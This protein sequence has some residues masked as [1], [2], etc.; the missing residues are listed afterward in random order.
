MYRI[1]NWRVTAMSLLRRGNLNRIYY[2]NMALQYAGNAISIEQDMQRN[3]EKIFQY[4][5]ENNSAYRA[6]LDSKGFDYSDL[7]LINWKDI[8]AITKEDLR[9]FNPV[10]IHQV[11][12]Y[13]KS[14]GSTNSPLRYPASK[15]SA[16][17]IWPNHWTMHAMCGIAPYEKMLMLMGH[18]VTSDSMVKRLYQWLSQFYTV[19]SFD[20]TPENAN[21]MYHLIVNKKIKFLYGYA[22][23][24]YIFLRYLHNNNLHVSLKGIFST[25][26]NVVPVSYDLARK[27][28]DCDLFNQYGAHDGDIFAF[29]CTAHDGLHI[30]HN[31]C[32]LEIIDNEI[33]LTATRNY[34][35]PFIRYRVGDIPFGGALV[36]EKCSCGRTLFRLQGISGRV[37][38]VVVDLDG[39]EVPVIMFTFPLD[40]D[41]SIDKY[42]VVEIDKCIIINII[43][44]KY[45]V[46]FYEQKHMPYIKN[47]LKRSVRFTLNEPLIQ[48]P[49]KK[50]PLYINHNTSV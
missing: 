31:G 23:S 50:V 19:C 27:Y 46:V 25:S 15:D 47:H 22:S 42:Q 12:N 49:N 39:K 14:G 29:E 8:P 21:K 7:L 43:S 35:Y 9:K 10:V 1:M 28:C 6:F 33:Y 45:D 17:S 26:E 34:A 4:H 2:E 40:E 3:A 32:T 37:N 20:L 48:L 41:L 36:K 30:L 44:D 38:N 11:Y 16:L 5:V 24:I 18:H 13:S